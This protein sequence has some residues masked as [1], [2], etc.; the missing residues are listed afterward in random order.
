MSEKRN[1]AMV[2][3]CQ[4]PRKKRG[5]EQKINVVKNALHTRLVGAVCQGQRAPSSAPR[6]LNLTTDSL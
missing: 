4:G 2:A 3:V 6:P 1:L 5:N